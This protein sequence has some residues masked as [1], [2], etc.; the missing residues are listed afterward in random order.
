M[1]IW[2]FQKFPIGGGG[3][4]LGGIVLWMTLAH[5]KILPVRKTVTVNMFQWSHKKNM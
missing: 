2:K 3:W 1:D 5:L 4:W